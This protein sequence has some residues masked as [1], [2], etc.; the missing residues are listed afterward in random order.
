MCETAPPCSADRLRGFAVAAEACAGALVNEPSAEVVREVRRVAQ[1]L[2]LQQFDCL[3]PGADLRQRYY[4]RFFVSASPYYVPLVES[5]IR[6]AWELDGRRSFGSANGPAADHAL[7]CYRAVGF[8]FR[9][10]DGFELAVKQLR[11]DSMACEL[12]FMAALARNACGCESDYAAAARSEKLLRQFV[13]E[14]AAG[15]FKAAESAL[16]RTDADFYADVCG[17]AADAVAVW[18]A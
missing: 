1:A 11:P 3:E 6:G 13:C 12:A 5:C 8:D 16:R 14:H 2:G 10:L 4:D 7:R 18:T 15:W 9:A 17:L